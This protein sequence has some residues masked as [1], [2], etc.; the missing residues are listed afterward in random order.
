MNPKSILCALVFACPVFATETSLLLSKNVRVPESPEAAVSG[1]ARATIRR[2]A[3]T[4]QIVADRIIFDHPNK[5]LQCVGAASITTGAQVITGADL[6]IELGAIARV[7]RLGDGAVSIQ[8]AGAAEM[9][10]APRDPRARF[11]EQMPSVELRLDSKRGSPAEARP[12]A[13]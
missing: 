5:R 10:T 4:T 3:E 2:G 11:G 9:P 7:Y 6:T 13:R 8:P 1:V 12:A